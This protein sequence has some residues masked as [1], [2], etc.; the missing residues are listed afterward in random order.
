MPKKIKPK[1]IALDIFYDMAT[2][3]AFLLAI[4]TA[5]WSMNPSS[6]LA[7]LYHTSDPQAQ[8]NVLLYFVGTMIVSLFL[9]LAIVIV[10]YRFLKRGIVRQDLATGREFDDPALHQVASPARDRQKAVTIPSEEFDKEVAWL[11]ECVYPVKTKVD[12][13]GKGKINITIYNDKQA[14]IGVAQASQD[15]DDK[16][17]RPEA[18]KS[19]NSYKAKANLARAFFVTTGKFTDDTLEQAQMMG[20][21]LIDGQLLD[22]WRK[23]AKAKAAT[24]QSVS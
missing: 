8:G 6:P 10:I 13:S 12:T 15:A 3:G 14:L 5:F 23:K 21:T 24:S 18:L 4:A 19:L 1:K 22:N 20:I 11:F 7:S 2:R 16:W 17:V 9:Y